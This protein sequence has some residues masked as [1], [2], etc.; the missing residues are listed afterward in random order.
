MQGEVLHQRGEAGGN[1]AK[2]LAEEV[3]Q[4]RR[5]EIRFRQTRASQWLHCASCNTKR[6]LKLLQEKRKKGRVTEGL[7][8]TWGCALRVEEQ[9]QVAV[10]PEPGLENVVFQTFQNSHDGSLQPLLLPQ[11]AFN[12]EHELVE[13]EAQLR[14]NA[15]NRD[16]VSLQQKREKIRKDNSP[17]EDA[18]RNRQRI[19]ILTETRKAVTAVEQA[20]RER[21]KSG[22]FKRALRLPLTPSLACSRRNTFSSA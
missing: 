10:R 13:A 2:E 1:E 9:V 21:R 17:Q 4:L 20:K 6:L 3:L 7:S 18:R 22:S 14:Q 8:A 12:H 19:I 11:K 15:I 5:L 16:V